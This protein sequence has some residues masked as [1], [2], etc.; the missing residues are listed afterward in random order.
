MQIAPETRLMKLAYAL[1]F[2]SLCSS[3]P[4]CAI[5]QEAG[6]GTAASRSAKVISPEV[7]PDSRV[8]FRLRAPNATAVMVEGN[9][10]GGKDLAMTKD[11]T[12]VWT[13]TTPAPLTPEL[14]AYTFS[15]DGLRG[16]DPNNYTVARDGVGFQNTFIISGSTPS[17]LQARA[18]P[19]GTMEQIWMKSPGLNNTQRRMEVYLPAGYEDSKEKYPVLYLFHGGGGDEEA[20]PTMGVVNIIM[21][22]LIAENKAKPM[23]VVMPNAYVTHVASL[24]VAGPHSNPVEAPVVAVPPAGAT[25]PVLNYAADEKEIVDGIVPFVDKHFRTEAHRDDRAIAGLSMGGGIVTGVG[26]K[27][28]DVFA[29]IGMFSTG[30]FMRAAKPMDAIMDV[31]PTFVANGAETNKKF[32]LVFISVGTEDP[33]FASMEAIT[34]QLKE[35]NIKFIYKTY[36]GQHEWKVWRNSMI[37]FVPMLF[38]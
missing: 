6:A 13:V 14:W 1:L 7:L 25:P 8:T 3:A 34:G 12:G 31:A 17:E 20:W 19:H 2:A 33:R 38:R 30:N 15:V 28:P 29:T 22:N 23:I 16:L 5:A 37:D 27:R 36:S 24:D 18:V 4:Y 10:A 11:A 21:D 35:K 26:M 32:K 9:W